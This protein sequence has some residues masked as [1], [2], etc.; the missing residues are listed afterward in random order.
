[1]QWEGPSEPEM[2]VC[3]VCGKQAVMSDEVMDTWHP[4]VWAEYP[5]GSEEEISPVCGEHEVTRDDETGVG[6]VR[7]TERP[8]HRMPPAEG[9]AE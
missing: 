8:S 5:D 2:V 7:L 1:M 9:T 3:G 4:E 6:V